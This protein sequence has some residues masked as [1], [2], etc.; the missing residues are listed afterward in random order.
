MI[1]EAFWKSCNVSTRSSTTI[2]GL[3]INLV[4]RLIKGTYMMLTWKKWSW[5][6]NRIMEKNVFLRLQ[7]MSV[8]DGMEFI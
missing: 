3:K 1:M 2:L 6:V 7:N 5:G 4:T 8:R